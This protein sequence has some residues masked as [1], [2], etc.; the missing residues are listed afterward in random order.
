[1]LITFLS[2]LPRKC[3]YK[4]KHKFIFRAAALM[5]SVLLSPQTATVMMEILHR[6]AGL[7][8]L[9]L[10]CVYSDDEIEKG[11]YMTF[12]NLN[13]TPVK[14]SKKLKCQTSWLQL[15]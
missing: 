1:M 2:P 13:D 10:I 8:P 12:M 6:C 5:L 4:A 11:S 14:T 15:C 3:A 7:T 9:T